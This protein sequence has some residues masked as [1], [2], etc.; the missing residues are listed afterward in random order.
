MKKSQIHLYITS[1][2]FVGFHTHL[3]AGMAA[4]SQWPSVIEILKLSI[5]L[6]HPRRGELHPKIIGI[7]P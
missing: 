5:S 4:V 7:L 6:E 3:A 2:F 1:L